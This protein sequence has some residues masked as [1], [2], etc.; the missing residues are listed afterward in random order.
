[1]SDHLWFWTQMQT[2]LGGDKRWV[3]IEHTIVNYGIP[4]MFQTGGYQ[5][6]SEWQCSGCPAG[7]TGNPR[8]TYLKQ[9]YRKRISTQV[10][11][12]RDWF[13]YYWGWHA[14]TTYELWLTIQQGVDV[15]SRL[16]QCCWRW[17]G[18]DVLIADLEQVGAETGDAGPPAS[19]SLPSN[20]KTSYIQKYKTE[21]TCSRSWDRDRETALVL[22]CTQICQC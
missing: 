14:S 9:R 16:K 6:W 20:R 7:V 1:M 17:S 3:F 10:N 4:D 12:T 15:R 19:F 22:Q 11:R 21:K 8:W 18:S 5:W 2:T 13:I